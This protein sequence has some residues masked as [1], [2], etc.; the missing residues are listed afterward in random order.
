MRNAGPSRLRLKA[1]GF[2]YATA[3]SEQME[4][5]ECSPE[6]LPRNARPHPASLSRL[7]EQILCSSRKP[8]PYPG[9]QSQSWAVSAIHEFS[10]AAIV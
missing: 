3:T 7:P 1:N 4:F 10:R 6:S 2:G 9:E 5:F 8:K